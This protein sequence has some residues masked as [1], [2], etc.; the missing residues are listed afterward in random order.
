MK[1]HDMH[2]DEEFFELI[3]NDKKH[4][5]YRLNDEKRKQIKIGDTITFY[6]RP[7][8]IEKIKVKVTDLKYYANLVDMYS[9]SFEDELK[10]SYDSIQEVIDSTPFYTEEKIKKYGCVAIHFKKID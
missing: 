6:K 4:I 5:E 7:L 9:A 10:F 1:N 2:L 8:E 3:K